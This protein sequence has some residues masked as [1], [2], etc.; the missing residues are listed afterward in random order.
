M[1]EWQT[2]PLEAF[3]PVIYI[4]ALVRHEA[5]CIRVEVKDLRRQVVAAA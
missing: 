5:P 3:Y 2:R 1:R 4:D